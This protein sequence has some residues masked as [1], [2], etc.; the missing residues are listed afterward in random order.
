MRAEEFSPLALYGDKKFFQEMVDAQFD[1]LQAGRGPQI[2][3]NRV[4]HIF[5]FLKGGIITAALVEWKFYDEAH[6]H[7]GREKKRWLTDKDARNFLAEWKVSLGNKEN[8]KDVME[9]W[10]AS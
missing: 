1:E 8:L 4:V 10:N 5:C 9:A 6:S 2:G 3:E 7:R